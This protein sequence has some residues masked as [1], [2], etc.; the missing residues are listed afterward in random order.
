MALLLAGVSSC[1]DYYDFGLPDHWNGSIVVINASS[2]DVV[3]LAFWGPDNV[4]RSIC[5]SPGESCEQ[6]LQ[7]GGYVVDV[8]WDDGSMSTYWDVWVK[9]F[10]PT[11]LYVTK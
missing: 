2:V 4:E 10:V 3:A 8:T 7:T 6:V 11:W 1:G 5:V 9:E